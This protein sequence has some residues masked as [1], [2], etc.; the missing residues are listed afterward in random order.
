MLKQSLIIILVVFFA[1]F[2]WAMETVKTGSEAEMGFTLPALPQE[3]Q[4]M[5]YMVR[6]SVV[7]HFSK[8]YV[9]LDKKLGKNRIGSTKGLEYIYFPVSPGKHRIFSEGRNSKYIDITVKAG[10]T[11]FIKQPVKLDVDGTN[12]DNM[13]I[14]EPE[15][16]KYIVSHL[17]MGW[18]DQH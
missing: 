17:T 12:L 15:I 18:L 5:I 1:G 14:L 8:F 3:G 11:V 13:I 10:E 7:D 2:S 9:Y 16:G 4:A 6:P